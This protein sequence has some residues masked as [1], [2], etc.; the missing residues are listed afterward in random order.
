VPNCKIPSASFC[1]HSADWPAAGNQACWELSFVAQHYP[2]PTSHDVKQER[3]D[4]RLD[5]YSST[6]GS[7][8]P[9]LQNLR[10]LQLVVLGNTLG[11][12]STLPASYSAA[13]DQCRTLMA[14]CDTILPLRTPPIL[15][16]IGLHVSL[17]LIVRSFETLLPRVLLPLHNASPSIACKRLGVIVLA[18][19]TT[20]GDY[21]QVCLYL[22]TFHTSIVIN[23]YICSRH[24]DCF[25]L[26]S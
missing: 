5:E 1:S 11:G 19:G 22:I 26:N 9:L 18:R 7:D 21:S 10:T 13:S 8:E 23:C 6:L 17:V 3:H 15:C 4:V 12:R 2:F 24:V 20:R 25:A 14:A 16:L